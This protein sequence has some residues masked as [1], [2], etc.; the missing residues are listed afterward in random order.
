[1]HRAWR[2][3][4]LPHVLPLGI[5]MTRGLV[6]SPLPVAG[7][8][9]TPEEGNGRP[10]RLALTT[11]PAPIRKGARVR[12]HL[13]CQPRRFALCFVRS[14]CFCNST[15]SDAGC[16][17]I[18]IPG[19]GNGARGA[20][21]CARL[22]TAGL[23]P[24]WCFPTAA[25]TTRLVASR[26]NGSASWRIV[27][28]LVTGE[29]SLPLTSSLSFLPVFSA[30]CDCCHLVFCLEHRTYSSHRCTSSGDKFDASCP[31]HFAR[32]PAKKT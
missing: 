6:P 25:F 9:N 31:P 28:V 29:Y 27:V 11:N 30:E 4:V 21:Q 10:M 18:D 13:C 19:S 2:P 16:A 14:D 7:Q 26:W 32:F 8:H 20:L 5:P 1:M 23:S 3:S 15:R 22:P 12:S 17:L 24:V